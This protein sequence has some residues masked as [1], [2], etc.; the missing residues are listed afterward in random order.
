MD[1]DDN[2]FA[3]IYQRRRSSTVD[4][5]TIRQFNSSS[6]DSARIVSSESRKADTGETLAKRV[7][8]KKSPSIPKRCSSLKIRGENRFDTWSPM[9]WQP[10]D[11]PALADKTIKDFVDL[12]KDCCEQTYKKV[13]DPLSQAQHNKLCHRIT[14]Y[15]LPVAITSR[16][17]PH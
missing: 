13:L 4:Y 9:D 7:K 1:G 12:F 14:N 5:P 2:D 17:S 16:E 3:P 11:E 8:E 6:D 10:K 15:A